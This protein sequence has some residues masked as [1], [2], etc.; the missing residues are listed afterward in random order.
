MMLRS[1]H[2]ASVLLFL[3]AN[4]LVA[5]FVLPSPALGEQEPEPVAPI[6]L[7]TYPRGSSPELI[8]DMPPNEG[9][10]FEAGFG[11]V[12]PGG[13]IY[14]Y[15]LDYNN[16]KVL[17]P[18][19]GSLLKL[20]NGPGDLR[21]ES[22]EDMAVTADGAVTLMSE[23]WT[24]TDTHVLCFR[25]LSPDASGWGPATCIPKSVFGDRP[26]IVG[27]HR[28]DA[29]PD[30]TVYV[31]SYGKN[32]SFP[33]DTLAVLVSENRLPT[34]WDHAIVGMVGA[35]GLFYPQFPRF[36]DGWDSAPV[37]EEV[38]SVR[39]RNGKVV[40]TLPGRAGYV[41]GV[42]PDG[43]VLF[44]NWG[45]VTVIRPTGEIAAVGALPNTKERAEKIVTDPGRL[46]IS[47]SG[48]IYELR[49]TTSG[50]EVYLLA[51]GQR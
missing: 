37:A 6:H 8:S 11:T 49:S 20:M 3:P 42:L 22:T 25:R 26:D 12:A 19:R 47:P 9:A 14:F 41:A 16:I 10:H 28:L 34:I 48:R 2:F 7:F 40:R 35:D 39:D 23:G 15:D 50:L 45:G 46:L 43:S 32:R 13:E 21:Y 27:S 33:V 51:G 17:D 36:P 30:G 38:V 1:I 24:S 5:L 4:L 31:Y 29:G 44:E 18:V